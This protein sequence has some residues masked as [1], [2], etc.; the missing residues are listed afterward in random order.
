MIALTARWLNTIGLVLG[1]AG[2]AILFKWGPPQPDFDEG[3][4][5]GASFTDDTVFRDGT[6]PSEIVAAVRRRKRLH[7]K[8]SSIG[9]GLIGLGFLAQLVAVWC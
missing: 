1:I 3:F 6:K 7:Q 5:I 2:V 8:M 4:A 9:L